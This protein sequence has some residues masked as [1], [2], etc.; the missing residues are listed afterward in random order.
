MTK[1]IRADFRKGA[2][3]FVR[4]LFPANAD[5]A[6]VEEIVSDVSA[7]PPEVAIATFEDLAR[8]DIGPALGKL[9]VPIHCINADL[10]PT[11]VDENRRAYTKYDVVFLPGLG[12][13][14]MLEAPAAFNE[15]L[16]QLIRDLAG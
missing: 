16:L 3:A 15:K 2:A 9:D 13:F 8:Y 4:Q 6:L 14:P 1:P 11:K 5:P 7:A 12:H 10:W